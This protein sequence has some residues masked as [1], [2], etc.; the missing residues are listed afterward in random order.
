MDT[1]S[2]GPL[3]VRALGRGDAGGPAILLCHGF[4]APGDDLVGLGRALD[5]GRGVR[6]F[7]PEAPIVIDFG[8][9]MTGRAWWE[10]DLGSLVEAQ[11]RGDMLR[12]AKEDPPGVATARGLLEETLDELERAHGVARD[13][14][15]IGGFSQGAMLATEVALNA[16]RPFAGLAVLSGALLARERW[17]KLA[18]A[19]G[20]AI[21]AFLTH[22]KAD[23]MLPFGGG[24][25]LRDLLTASGA[26]VTWV[27]H[28][29]QHEIP[30]PALDGL[31]NFA[32]AAFAR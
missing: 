11:A 2:I 9:G 32:R 16:E 28:G 29:G 21:H 25:A 26:D 22:G 20:A 18:I 24:E 1:T 3:R 6:W 10:I 14:L 13:K 30:P 17:S 8:G 31:V 5:V 23:P 15:V 7:F 4:G 27:A 12:L 19:R